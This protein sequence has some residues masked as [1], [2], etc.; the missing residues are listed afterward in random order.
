MNRWNKKLYIT[1]FYLATSDV[2][3]RIDCERA[4]GRKRHRVSKAIV[5]KRLMSFFLFILVFLL[6]LLH[7]F[8]K[9]LFLFFFFFKITSRNRFLE[10]CLM[11]CTIYTD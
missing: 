7:L 3:S 6:L 2:L 8:L 11:F 1:I 5:G 9:V 10:I 4:F